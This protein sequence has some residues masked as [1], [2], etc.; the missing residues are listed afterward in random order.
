MYDNLIDGHGNILRT[1]KMCVKQVYKLNEGEKVLVHVNPMY[2]LIGNAGG[3][4]SRFMTLLLKEPNICPPDAKD[5]RECKKRC[6]VMLL[7]ELRVIHSAKETIFFLFI[8]QLLITVIIHLMSFIDNFGSG[9]ST[10]L[11]G[12]V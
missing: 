1:Q 9:D 12:K 11:M 6:G 10:Y 7:V 3:L 4:C 5:W 2:Q 8:V